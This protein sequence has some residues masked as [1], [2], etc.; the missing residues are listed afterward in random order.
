MLVFPQERKGDR[1]K[2]FSRNK[3]YGQEEQNGY[4]KRRAE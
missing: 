3:Q 2:A 4:R 1:F